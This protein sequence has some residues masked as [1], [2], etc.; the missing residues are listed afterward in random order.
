MHTDIEDW[1]NG[2]FG[3]DLGLRREEIADLIQSLNMLINEPDQHFHLDSNYKGTGGIGQ[4]TFYV[5]SNEEEDDV[6]LGS[7][8]YSPGEVITEF[9]I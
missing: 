5:K 2:W 1:K 4:I 7:R 9:D 6:S 8:A 3:I